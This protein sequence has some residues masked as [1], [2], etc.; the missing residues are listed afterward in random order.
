MTSAETG[1][2]KPRALLVVNPVARGAPHIDKLRRAT[3]WLES[4]GWEAQL[5]LTEES[6]HATD[7][8][9]EAAASGFDVVVACG[10]DGTINEV[11]NGLAGMPTALAVIRGGTANVWAKEASI[12]RD[13]IDAVRLIID[14]E[15]RRMDLGV[16]EPPPGEGSPRHFLLMAG[17]GLDGH[18]VS[19]VPGNLKKRFGSFS[20]VFYGLREGLRYKARKTEL[21]IDGEP[22]AV[23]LSWLLAA[24]T[25]SY[26]GVINV[27]HHALADD[28]LLDLYVFEG[29]G[30]RRSL[31]H[32]L[33]VLFRRH[34]SALLYRRAQ[35]IELPASPSFEA[36]VDGD[37]LGFA[38]RVLRI[39]P[40]ALT[41]VLPKTKKSPLF[42]S[43]A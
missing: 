2:S 22:V 13:P 25:R 6:G 11:A 16:A 33:R 41:V 23:D 27:A 21:V 40:Q 7:L 1:D 8:A 14:G 28:G 17:I 38:P 34:D 42:T 5:T 15:R 36:Q 37:P 29:Q 9:R 26:G 12:P 32:G 43:P 10:G 35:R 3:A 19:R 18:I 30:I 31:A 20:Y 39:A 4:Q 24:N